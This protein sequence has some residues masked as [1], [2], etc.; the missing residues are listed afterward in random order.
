M[1]E[2]FLQNRNEE[3]GAGEQGTDKLVKK[4]KKDT[5]GA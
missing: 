2:K 3:H 1:A 5:P 4:Y